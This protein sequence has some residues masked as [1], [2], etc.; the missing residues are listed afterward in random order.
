MK[1]VASVVNEMM[2]QNVIEFD[3]FLILAYSTK[4]EVHIFEQGAAEAK[5]FFAVQVVK[6]SVL[7]TDACLVKFFQAIGLICNSFFVKILPFALLI[8]LLR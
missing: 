1:L 3:I 7:G 5:F 8:K 2:Q 4:V 6:F